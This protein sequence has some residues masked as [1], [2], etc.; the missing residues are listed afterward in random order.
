MAFDKW[1]GFDLI[2]RKT[3]EKL[4]AG[5]A[6]VDPAALVALQEAVDDLTDRVEALEAE[7]PA[8]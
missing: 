4:L 8:G 6:G 1:F 2:Q 7:A 3:L 5:V